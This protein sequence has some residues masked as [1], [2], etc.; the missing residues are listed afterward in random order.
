MCMNV[1][2][3]SCMYIIYTHIC[4]MYVHH[5]HKYTHTHTVQYVHVYTCGF[6]ESLRIQMVQ[7]PFTST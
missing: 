3:A 4:H 5:M 7:K 1:S 6:V 2:N